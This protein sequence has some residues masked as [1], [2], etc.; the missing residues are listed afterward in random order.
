MFVDPVTHEHVSVDNCETDSDGSTLKRNRA[1]NCLS[2]AVDME[3]LGRLFGSLV[4][5]LRSDT[6]SGRVVA[7]FIQ[8]TLDLGF[9]ETP[10]YDKWI[11]KFQQLLN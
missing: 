8:Y 2:R 4:K 11:E 9:K 10:N 3:D 6:A 5:Q 7:E 1:E